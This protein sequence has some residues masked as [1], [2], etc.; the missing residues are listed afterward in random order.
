MSLTKDR[1]QELIEYNPSIGNFIWKV[2]KGTRS[3][4]S[5][6]GSTNK[7]G[8]IQIKIDGTTYFAHRLAY[9][10]MV[11][12]WPA[13]LIDHKNHNPSDNRWVNLREA[14]YTTNNLNRKG[15]TKRNALGVR[16]VSRTTGG[17]FR[18][19]VR[20]NG[21]LNHLGTFDTIEQAERVQ[22]KYLK[23]MCGEN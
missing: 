9:L 14:D 1:L 21:V 5:L 2:S 11:G 4:G 15:P 18:A 8:Y 10:L 20:Y 3:A 13:S 22:Q 7:K 19:H 6:A 12:R 16:G 17:K 23:D